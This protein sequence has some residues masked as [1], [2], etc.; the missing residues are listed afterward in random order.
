MQEKRRITKSHKHGS[1]G[2]SQHQTQQ[3]LRFLKLA[4]EY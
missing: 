1:K 3:F 2:V 4:L